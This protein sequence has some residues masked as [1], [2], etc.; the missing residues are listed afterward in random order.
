MG[1]ETDMDT[2]MDTRVLILET[3][4]KIFSDHCDKALLDA[5]ETGEFARTLW[6]QLTG[7]GFHQL[8]SPNSGTDAKDMYAFMMLCGQYAVPLPI[9]E[10][11]LVNRWCGTDDGV[12]SLGHIDGASIVD[13]PWGRVA[14]RVVGIDATAVKVT[15]TLNVQSEHVSLAGEPRDVVALDA[16][17][18]IVQV[19]DAFAQ[20]TLARINQIAGGLQALLDLGLQFATE[21]AQ[22]GRPIAKFQAIQHSLAVVA[23]EAAAARRAADAAVDA[24]DG[25]RFVLEVAASKARVGEAV[26]LVAEQVHQIHGAMG[27]THEHRLHHFSRRVWSWRD[28]WGNEV[29]WQGMLGRHLATLGADRVWDF[30]ATPA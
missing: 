26:G 13:V 5:A 20:V 15:S 27:F 28:E 2:D 1:S 9:A 6:S 3:A 23:S 16:D 4:A 14:N 30:I 18:Q 17:A 24:M 7:N 21:R 22:F 25:P 12:G 10:T 29:Y 11:L 19:Q 8:G